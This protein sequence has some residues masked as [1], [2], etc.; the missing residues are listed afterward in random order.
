MEL[1]R[2]VIAILTKKAAPGLKSDLRLAPSVRSPPPS[3]YTMTAPKQE[4]PVAT[5]EHLGK[6]HAHLV[7]SVFSAACR[8]NRR[9]KEY[10]EKR[11]FWK[12]VRGGKS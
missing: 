7:L 6:G 2:G 10:C 3:L 1:K 9:V 5:L 11:L 4:R 12:I 8:G